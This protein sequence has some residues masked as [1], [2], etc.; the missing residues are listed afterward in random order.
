MHNTPM[1][2]LQDRLTQDSVAAVHDT[3]VYLGCN[4]TRSS[5]CLTMQAD[6]CFRKLKES[7]TSDDADETQVNTAEIARAT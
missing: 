3:E 4:V 5:Q 2:A 7:T 6:W 1:F